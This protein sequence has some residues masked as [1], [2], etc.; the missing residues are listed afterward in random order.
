MRFS[1][2]SMIIALRSCKICH[3][4]VW[5]HFTG[6]M[7]D[8]DCDEMSQTWESSQRVSVFI[9]ASS[10]ACC[11]SLTSLPLFFITYSLGW[12]TDGLANSFVFHWYMFIILHLEC[13]EAVNMYKEPHVL[14][15]VAS[16]G[17]CGNLAVSNSPQFRNVLALPI[18]P[19]Q[20]RLS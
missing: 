15:L 12:K 4:E 7:T 18:Y 6:G 16:L 3:H 2:R 13:R 9:G 14:V 11:F 10:C 20:K 17:I 1:F 5:L 8:M 19:A